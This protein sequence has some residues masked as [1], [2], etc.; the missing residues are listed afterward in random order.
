MTDE[1]LKAAG[2]IEAEITTIRRHFHLNPELSY[3]EARTAIFIGDTLKR[4][5]IPHRSGVGGNGL[6]ADIGGTPR[7]AI[8]ADMD[9]L[10]IQEATELPFCSEIQ[11][12]AHLCG[13]DAH[14]AMALGAA[15]ILADRLSSA[16]PGVRMIFQ[17]AEEIP[18]GGA[19][20]MIRDGALEGIRSIIALHVGPFPIGKFGIRKGPL[21]AAVDQFKIT[22][23][24]KGTH[25]AAPHLGIDPVVIAAQIVLALQTLI[26]R[27]KSPLE[28]AVLSVCHILAG[29]QYNIIPEKVMMEG[30]VRSFSPEVREMVL[31]GAARIVEHYAESYGARG[32]WEIIAGHGSV[33][34]DDEIAGAA[35]EVVRECWGG[36]SVLEIPP[37]TFG[38]DFT[39]YG[40]KARTFMALLGVGGGAALHSPNFLLDESAMKDGAA[41]LAALAWRLR[42]G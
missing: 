15:K 35:G 20:A 1:F 2:G 21:T 30:T 12:V 37:Q 34:N 39:N 3:H 24:G 18:P 33:L 38:E 28:P 27:A 23:A 8:R 29:Q 25:G 7:V 42:E 36:E 19:E 31:A 6:V 40:Q 4:W 17:P 26:S 32:I 14:M 16:G 9:A 5:G 10:P 11:G 13:H 41:F 22:I